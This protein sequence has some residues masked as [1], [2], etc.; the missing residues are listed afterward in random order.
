MYRK[1]LVPLDGSELAEK[2]LPHVEALARCMGAEVILLRVPVFAYE[3]AVAM[4]APYGIAQPSLPD[5]RE[6]VL[7]D[8][9][10]YLNKLKSDLCARGLKVWTVVREGPP[11]EA[12]IEFARTEG[13]DLIAMTTHGRTGLSRAV[14]GSVAAQVLRGVDKPVLLI[15]H[16]PPE[17]PQS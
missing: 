8:A 5:L 15:Q 13:V 16:R 1:I 7:K 6:D 3:S 12:I 17:K 4:L 14:F 9:A 2:V 11:S 10:S